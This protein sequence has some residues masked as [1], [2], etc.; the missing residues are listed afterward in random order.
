M[1]SDFVGR[2]RPARYYCAFLERVCNTRSVPERLKF[3]ITDHF[4]QVRSIE[5]L[6]DLCESVSACLRPIA[7]NPDY[8]T[9]E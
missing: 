7:S 6:R 1:V 9:V 3:Q 8:F 5:E 4:M 2:L